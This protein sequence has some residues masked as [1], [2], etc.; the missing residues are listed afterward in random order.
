MTT[1]TENPWW[2]V[3]TVRRYVSSYGLDALAD[4]SFFVLLGWVAAHSLGQT[5]AVLTIAAASA[6]KLIVLVLFGGALGD[7]YGAARV[8]RLTLLARVALLVLL[9]AGLWL[10]TPGWALLTVAAT[11]GVVDGIHDP[12]IE[13]LSTEIPGAPSA[14]RGLQGAL[15]TGRELGLLVAGPAI[16]GMLVAVSSSVAALAIAVL[17]IMAWV[18][19]LG[20]PTRPSSDH[21]DEEAQSQGLF[22]SAREGWGRAWGLPR[23]RTMLLIFFV[24]NAVLTP[25]VAVG[26]PLLAKGNGWSSFQF[27]L[28]DA[29]YAVGALL[30]AAAISRWGDSIRQPVRVALLS[31]LPTA[32]AISF[33]GVPN[34]W[35][36][37]AVLVAV[38]GVSTGL[39]PS[40]LGGAIK[41]ETPAT[42]MSRV[43]ASRAAAVVAGTPVGF[44]LFAALAALW[45]VPIALGVLGGVLAVTVLV[46]LLNIPEERPRP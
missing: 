2:S 35:W 27:G 44:G 28:V 40:L 37:A 36:Y 1:T 6:L 29:S 46:A 18:L 7:R 38:A 31:L 10:S 24:A 13:A 33:V 20:F 14:Q 16:G 3:S 45:S 17:L 26:I 9:A 11:Y 8:A 19:I 23:L 39:G 5:S 22:S 42:L 21:V 32:V 4:G 41:E 30:G 25:P 12:V 15:T 34:Q 43:Q